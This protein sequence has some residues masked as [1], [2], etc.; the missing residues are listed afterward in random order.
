M[1]ISRFAVLAFACSPFPTAVLAD[2]IRLQPAWSG[3]KVER[4]ITLLTPADGTGRLFLVQQR[5]KVVILPATDAGTE[6]KTFL[7]LS[8]RKMEENQFEEG[9]IGFAFHPKYK[10]NGRFYVCYSQQDPKRSIVSE[11]KVSAADPDKADPV[12]ERILL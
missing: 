5:G 11:F 4:P 6:T 3:V 9:L 7:D 8:D 2:G 1:N 10:E 12:S